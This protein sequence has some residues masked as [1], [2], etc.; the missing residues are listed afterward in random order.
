MQRANAADHPIVRMLCIRKTDGKPSFS[1]IHASRP[2]RSRTGGYSNAVLLY[3]IS[4]KIASVFSDFL[5]FGQI[6]PSCTAGF[7]KNKAKPAEKQY[8]GSETGTAVRVHDTAGL[9]LLRCAD[10]TCICASAAFET[11][12]C[13]NHVL[14]VALR[15]RADRTC[16]CTCTALDASI[17]DSVCHNCYL[18]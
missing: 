5:R 7:M 18:L 15:D 9:L 11:C 8:G 17:T 14:A 12:L 2:R 4:R 10:R 3:H 13:I 16:I 1:R 6:S